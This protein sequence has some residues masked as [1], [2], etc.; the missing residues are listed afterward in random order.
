MNHLHVT[1]SMMGQLLNGIFIYKEG[2]GLSI[3]FKMN[4]NSTKRINVPKCFEI[5]LKGLMSKFLLK[6][7]LKGLMFGIF[8]KLH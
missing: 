7:E 2:R 8:G 6:M 3:L 5:V 1:L 4:T